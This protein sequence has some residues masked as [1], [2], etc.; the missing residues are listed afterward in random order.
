MT[1]FRKNSPEKNFWQPKNWNIIYRETLGV[2]LQKL[3]N[4][5]HGVPGNL[6]LKN[7]TQR[8]IRDGKLIGII[9]TCPCANGLHCARLKSSQM[10]F[11]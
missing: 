3:D 2:F 7:E 4:S 11:C 6:V 9:L 1:S 5:D 8:D 10:I